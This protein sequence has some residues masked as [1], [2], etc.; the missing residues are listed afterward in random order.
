[1]SSRRRVRDTVTVVVE[2]TVSGKGARAVAKP[3]VAPQGSH[4][5]VRVREIDADVLKVALK[6]AG[7]DY[8]RLRFLEDG[9][10]LVTNAPRA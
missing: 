10:V 1:M 6:V 3:G 8:R 9:S 7:G 5:R 2:T 4:G